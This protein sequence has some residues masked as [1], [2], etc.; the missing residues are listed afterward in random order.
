MLTP[1]QVKRIKELREEG[2]TY[3]AIAGKVKCSE[4]SVRKYV[5]DLP[6]RKAEALPPTVP[7]NPSSPVLPNP[8]PLASNPNPTPLM[9][10]PPLLMPP[11]QIMQQPPS[12]REALVQVRG[13]PVG[14][15]ILITPKNLT[16]IQWFQS[17]Y[18]WK[19]DLSDFIND[20]VEFFF[21]DGLHAKMQVSI[22]EEVA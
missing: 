17:K 21:S 22:E 8:T 10:S 4:S 15:K 20:A 1:Q 7:D 19:G 3:Q 5:L 16:M 6:S 2:Y 13:I 12:E 11:A 9:A 14:K 18:A